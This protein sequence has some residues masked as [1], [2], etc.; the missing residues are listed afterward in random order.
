MEYRDQPTISWLYKVITTLLASI[1]EANTEIPEIERLCKALKDQ[2][3]TRFAN[4]LQDDI[5][6]IAA[7]IDPAVS[8]LLTIQ[9]CNRA[10]K[11]LVSLVRF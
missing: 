2:I 7:Y 6:I 4:I 9:E 8:N 11:A 5:F 1:N 10:Q 3:S